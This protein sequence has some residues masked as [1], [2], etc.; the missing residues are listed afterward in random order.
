MLQKPKLPSTRRLAI[1]AEKAL[2][3]TEKRLLFGVA[4]SSGLTENTSM[5][6]SCDEPDLL[7]HLAAFKPNLVLLLGDAPLR[8]AKNYVTADHEVDDSVELDDDFFELKVLKRK[9]PI[10]AYRGTL[11]LGFNGTYKCM[12]TYE[13]RTVFA[14]YGEQIFPLQLDT[15]RAAEE[16]K[17]PVLVLPKRNLRVGLAPD[18]TL[19]LLRALCGKVAV[20][21]EGW[22]DSVSCIGFATSATEAFIVPTT[23][24]YWGD[25]L[26][27]AWREIA[28]VLQSPDIAKI[29]QNG[30]YD[31]FVLQY[32]YSIA[33]CNI[34]DDTML[35]HWELFCELPK[36]L[37]FQTSIYTRE[38]YYKAER[39][40]TDLE[41]FWTYCCKDAAVTFE[42]NELL[43]SKLDTRARAHYR[44]NM[45]MLDPILYM[46]LNGLGFDSALRD[47]KLA[48][49]D[50][51]R[52]RLVYVVNML[53]GVT[54]DNLDWFSIAADAFCYKKERHLVSDVASF[55]AH[56]KPSADFDISLLTRPLDLSTIGLLCEATG[57]GLNISSPQ[58]MCHFLYEH[59]GLPVQRKR[60]SDNATA[61]ALTLL[62]LFSKTNNLILRYI[63]M[64]RGVSTRSRNLRIK[65]DHDG[66]VRCAYN[67]VGTETGRLTC[68]KSP[69][70]SGFNLQTVTKKD[71]AL[72]VADPGYYL[73]QC[74]LAGADGWT[75]AAHCAKA[76]DTTMLDDYY[77]GLKP[78]KIIALLYRHG[79]QVLSWPRERIKLESKAISGDDWIYFTCKCVQHGTNYLM[80][81]PTVVD[82]IV[83]LSYKLFGEPIYAPLET[84]VELQNFYFRRYEGLRI[85][86]AAAAAALQKSARL[87][88]ANGHTRQFFSRRYDKATLRQWLAHEPQ[89]NT[90][91]ATNLAMMRLWNCR[92]NRQPDDSLII[93]PMHTI[94]DALMGQFPIDR[95]SWAVPRI[96]SYF[97]NPITIAGRSIT[98]PFEGAYGRSWGELT[99]GEI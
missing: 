92:E 45:S 48:V 8:L 94:H 83:R 46:Q 15:R 77:F 13:P 19:A 60:G 79:S 42:I 96:R 27:E 25:R 81:P 91:Y 53:A 58:A 35:K 31:V 1:L 11:F 9:T 76:G 17:T 3:E 69:T 61:D 86:H 36:S 50:K 87:T 85:Q 7:T 80:Q 57:Y 28:R 78:A 71:R 95:T 59:L 98:I 63:L 10:D 44:F 65:L 84:C 88:S 67:V 20:D 14:F 99:V 37:G 70:G 72:F 93:R 89:D 39:G 97:N 5:L 43:E 6:V 30:L 74:D 32:S 49:L 38:P 24:A 21:I 51:I 34:A 52:G 33:T 23:T 4:S 40:S 62:K 29:F 68:Y 26:P 2:S 56:M 41:T 18:D 54:L 55:T 73:F 12:A 82:T 16:S 64:L 75:V 47:T 66:R 22:V 90:T